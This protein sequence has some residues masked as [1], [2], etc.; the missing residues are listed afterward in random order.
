MKKFEMKNTYIISL[1]IV[2]LLM[3]ACNKQYTNNITILK[4]E[5]LLS[6]S[7]DSAYQLLSTIS[8]PEQLNKNDYA[9]WCLHFTYAQYKLYKNIKSDSLIQIAVDYYANSKLKKYSGLSY[10]LLG[11]VSELLN[12]NEKAMLAYK[13]ALVTLED[14]G[15]YNTKGL[16]YFNMGFIYRQ[17]KN[18]YLANSCYK[19]S[20]KFFNL[21]GNKKFQFYSCVELT[22]MYRLLNYPFDSVMLYS[23]KSLKLSREI[24]DSVMY[25]RLISRQGELQ[26]NID[27]RKSINNLLEGFK[28]LPDLQIRNASFLAYVY[29]QENMPDS[30]SYYL[31]IAS[32]KEMDSEMEIIKDLAK[33]VVSENHNNFKQAYYSFKKAYSRQDTIF[34][35]KLKSQLYTIDKQFDLSE[36]ENENAKLKIS[37]RNKVILIALLLIL[38]LLAMVVVLLINTNYKKNQAANKI[39]QQKMEFELKEKEIENKTKYDLLLSKLRQKL[40]VTI[41]FKKIQLGAASPK[42]QEEFIEELTNQIVLVEKEWQYYIDETNRLFNNKIAVLQKNHAQLTSSDMIV[43]AL[44]SLG[45]NITDS[46]ILLNSSKETMYMRRKRI[47]KRLEIEA[48]DDLEEWL[49]KNI[50]Y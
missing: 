47:K 34:Q 46:C 37:N 10:Y 1:C 13:N 18:F 38:V 26:F 9:A 33:A 15:E 28:H 41:H 3:S 45:M 11:G 20:L 8:H 7:P 6:E 21:S 35:A 36:K 23:N 17:D 50:S 49:K 48:V 40:E 43:I 42:K 2:T 16:T 27:R 44:I 14:I 12:E 30:A 4:A 19:E 39:K 25:Y 32:K 29:S 24:N 5:S 22:D 31:Q